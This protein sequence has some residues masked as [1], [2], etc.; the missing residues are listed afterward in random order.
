M[1]Q[2]SIQLAKQRNLIDIVIKQGHLHTQSSNC[3]MIICPFHS[4]KRPSLAIYENGFYCFACSERGDT[5]DWIMSSY[6]LDFIQ[7]VKVLISDK[8]LLEK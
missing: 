8:L 7:A 6:D 1:N 4:E 5:I 3:I 2:R